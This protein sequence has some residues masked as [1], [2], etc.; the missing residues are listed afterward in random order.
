MSGGR[1]VGPGWSQPRKRTWAHPSAGPSPAGG[2]IGV[3]CNVHQVEATSRGPGVP[4]SSYQDITVSL[5]RN[6]AHRVRCL[7]QGLRSLSAACLYL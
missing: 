1:A 2:A 5:K 7:S 6:T 4:I 3:G